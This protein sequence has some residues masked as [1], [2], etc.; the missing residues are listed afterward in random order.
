M[1][2]H[3][4]TRSL[5]EQKKEE[6]RR[7]LSRSAAEL[8]LAEG[9]DG[10]TVAAIA[11]RAGVSTRTFH[12]YFARRED[13]LLTFIEDTIE[14]WCLQVTQAPATESPLAIMHRLISDRVTGDDDPSSDPSTLLNLMSIGDHLSYV[15]GPKDKKRVMLLIDGLNE[16]LYQRESNTLSRQATT[17][18]MVSCISAGAIAVEVKRHPDTDR[19]GL[20]SWIAATDRSYDDILDESFAILRAGFGG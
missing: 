20:P 15:A 19:K 5:R 16:A 6:T 1:C 17:L 2:D 14:E 18:L 11:E 9:S 10:M 13:A 12:N 7:A 8:L 3:D 4:P